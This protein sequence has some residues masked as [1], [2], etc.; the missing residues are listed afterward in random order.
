MVGTISNIGKGVIL[1]DV[2]PYRT[3]ELQWLEHLWN[4]EY[5]LFEL[6]SVNHS[7]RS[8]GRIGISFSIFFNSK[9]YCVISLESPHRD[10]SNE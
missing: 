9:V 6:M 1:L 3:V 4:H 10:D 2:N 7:A 8:G 5:M